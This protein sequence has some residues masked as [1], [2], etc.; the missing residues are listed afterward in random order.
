MSARSS[1]SR[2][3]Q[4]QNVLLRAGDRLAEMAQD[5]IDGKI[6]LSDLRYCAYI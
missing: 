6:L 2:C 5:G 1:G 3:R 4:R